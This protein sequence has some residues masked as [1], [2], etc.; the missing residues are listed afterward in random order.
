MSTSK[1]VSMGKDFGKR[2]KSENLNDVLLRFF[3]NGKLLEK[4]MNV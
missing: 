3:D 2:I 4:A 1:N